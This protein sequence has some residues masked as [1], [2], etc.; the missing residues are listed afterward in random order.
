[1]KVVESTRGVLR[2]GKKRD[3]TLI[4]CGFSDGSVVRGAFALE[5]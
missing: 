3:C 1:V 5:M 2:P 4:R